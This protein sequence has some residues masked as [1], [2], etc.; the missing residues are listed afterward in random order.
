M[1]IKIHIENQDEQ[2]TIMIVERTFDKKT[3]DVKETILHPVAPKCS[4]T[5]YVHLLKDIVVKEIE[6]Q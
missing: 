2:R 6:P 1:T 3:R 5:V 4:T